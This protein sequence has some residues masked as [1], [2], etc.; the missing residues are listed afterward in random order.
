[1]EVRPH[2]SEPKI[3]ASTPVATMAQQPLAMASVNYKIDWFSMCQTSLEPRLSVSDFVS[4]L[5]RNIGRK[6]RKDFAHGQLYITDFKKEG[7]TLVV[8]KVL[9]LECT[10]MPSF[11]QPHMV[12]S[13]VPMSRHTHDDKMNQTFPSLSRES[14]GI[15]LINT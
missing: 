12:K 10:W 5:W 13:R 3:T 4:Q 14:L 9:L 6:T 15:R 1:M 8:L 2:S 11:V 7:N